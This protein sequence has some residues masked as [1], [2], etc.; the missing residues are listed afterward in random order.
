MCVCSFNLTKQIPITLDRELGRCSRKSQQVN[1][2]QRKSSF[3]LN[4]FDICEYLIKDFF[5]YDIPII[6]FGGE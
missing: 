5:E 6:S 3:N 4:K 2:F 1:S